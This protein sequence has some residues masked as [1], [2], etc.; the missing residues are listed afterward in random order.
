MR[1]D[2]VFANALSPAVGKRSKKNCSSCRMKEQQQQQ[3]KKW[4]RCFISAYIL[5]HF[6]LASFFRTY[7]Y[8][9]KILAIISKPFIYIMYACY[10]RE[11]KQQS[12]VASTVSAVRTVIHTSSSVKNLSITNVIQYF[13]LIFPEFPSAHKPT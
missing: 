2:V 8:K 6:I 5:F 9:N 11:S 3:T 1:H 7:I 12:S 10:L 13:E 4:Y